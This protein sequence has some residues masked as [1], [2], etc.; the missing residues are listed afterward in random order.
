MRPTIT[1]QKQSSVRSAL[2]RSSGPQYV[3]STVR[4]IFH[5]VSPSRT[6]PFRPKDQSLEV[7]GF[8]VEP[9]ELIHRRLVAALFRCL[10]EFSSCAGLLAASSTSL[11]S[12]PP[13]SLMAYGSITSD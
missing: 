10:A 12:I 13:S 8:A 11:S 5:Q 3:A 9:I 1:R 7:V 4:Q 6:K 2:K